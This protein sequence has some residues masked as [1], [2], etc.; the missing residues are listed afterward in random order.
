MPY[1]TAA[2]VRARIDKTNI[3]DD[4]IITALITAAEIAINNWTNHPDGFEALTVATARLFVGNGKGYLLIDE[5][6]EVEKVEVKSSISDTTFTEWTAPATAVSLDGDWIPGAGDPQ[7]PLFGQTPYDLLLVDINGGES[8]FTSGYL[9]RYSFGGDYSMSHNAARHLRP[10]QPTVR[11]T[12]KW[13]YS[14]TPPATIKEAC[15]M[16]V[17]RWYKRLQGAMSD[18]LASTEFGEISYVQVL[19]PDIKAILFT[20]RYVKPATGRR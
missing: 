11:V 13:G 17:A 5:N 3:D 8:H 10:G 18:S 4:T 2:E 14:I 20:G 9:G 12:A 6:A 15:G 19:D 7:S 16:Q 1:I